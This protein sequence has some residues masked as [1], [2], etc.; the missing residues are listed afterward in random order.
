[1]TK[2]L[3]FEVINN[4][5]LLGLIKSFMWPGQ[6]SANWYDY[7]DGNA[8]IVNGYMDI[9]L[10]RP[11]VFDSPLYAAV[12]S[13]RA[14]IFEWTFYTLG[15]P[16]ESDIILYAMRTENEQIIKLASKIEISGNNPLSITQ[17][18]V[19]YAIE[20][21]DLVYLDWYHDIAGQRLTINNINTAVTFDK[22]DVLDWLDNKKYTLINTNI[23]LSLTYDNVNAFK[24]MI[25]HGYIIG[26]DGEPQVKSTT[27]KISANAA[28]NFA[29]YNSSAKCARLLATYVG[30]KI[31]VSTLI[32]AILNGKGN[33]VIEIMEFL[34][35]DTLE[36]IRKTIAYY[37][38]RGVDDIAAE[39]SKY[40]AG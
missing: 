10:E 27:K 26:M 8:A 32:T 4:R 17:S 39:L 29:I 7:E 30:S 24:W 9:L 16:C 13:G 40:L 25:D 19:R 34:S 11:L 22:T 21:S 20:N 23:I 14:D 5:D 31:P 15:H 18:T 3:F 33:S 2:S 37:Q 1:M 28:M 12:A 36:E 38:V 35:Q 6:R